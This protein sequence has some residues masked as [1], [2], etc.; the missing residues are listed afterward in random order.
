MEE[1]FVTS[2]LRNRK[3]N[4]S[5]GDCSK[6]LTYSIESQVV[7]FGIRATVIESFFR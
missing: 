7:V 2:V 1:I 5:Y 3:G 6:Y 4:L